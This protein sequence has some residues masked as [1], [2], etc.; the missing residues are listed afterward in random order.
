MIYIS[1]QVKVLVIPLCIAAKIHNQKMLN[2]NEKL[3]KIKC[4]FLNPS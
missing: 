3:L 4:N 2:V 1:E